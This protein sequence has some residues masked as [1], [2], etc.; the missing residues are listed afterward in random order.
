[1]KRVIR[2]LNVPGDMMSHA[3]CGLAYHVNVQQALDK[4]YRPDEFG[5][6]HA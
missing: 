3:R 4:L 6:G 5:T 1:M 2:Q